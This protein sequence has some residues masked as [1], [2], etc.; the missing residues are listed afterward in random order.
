M[1]NKRK[2]KGPDYKLVCWGDYSIPVPLWARWM[3]WDEDGQVYIYKDEPTIIKA[4]F[5]PSVDGIWNSDSR[6]ELLFTRLLGVPPPEPGP[7]T[8]QLYW[9]GD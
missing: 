2:G 8:E 1:T 6:L 7:W 5:S 4:T 3:A 9:I